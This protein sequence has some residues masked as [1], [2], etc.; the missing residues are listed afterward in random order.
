MLQ[1]SHVT[2]IH[3][4]VWM[5]MLLTLGCHHTSKTQVEEKELDTFF[6]LD[7]F[8]FQD[9]YTNVMNMI[10]SKGFREIDR[11]SFTQDK[12]KEMYPIADLMVTYEADFFGEPVD[13]AFHF[14]DKQFK[15]LILQVANASLKPLINQFTLDYGTPTQQG[16]AYN[17]ETFKGDN[18]LWQIYTEDQQP[19]GYISLMPIA[20]AGENPE[21]WAAI[22]TIYPYSANPSE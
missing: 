22:A 9:S 13:M 21:D 11:V 8:S 14:K 20:G 1:W 2:K 6:Q 19:H 17:G 10:R 15:F 4:Y 18:I 16:Q 7:G 3:W 12:D 5:M